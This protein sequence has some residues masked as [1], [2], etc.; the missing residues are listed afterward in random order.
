MRVPPLPPYERVLWEGYAS[1]ADHVLLYIFMGAAFLR[2][3][4]A[5]RAS[6][7][8]TATLYLLAIGFFLGIAALFHYAAYYQISSQRIR[9]ASGLWSMQTR[10]ILLDQVRS[11]TVRRE[12]LNRFFDLGSLEI[13]LNEGHRS[14]VMLK[15][16]SN[17][18]RVKRQVD[19]LAGLRVSNAPNAMA[20]PQA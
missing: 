3:M 6:E 1:W 20:T 10:E 16:I 19:L 5:V 11:V 9:I 12:L 7:L 8:L 15:G 2:A 4:L 18:D 17:P 14:P 13:T